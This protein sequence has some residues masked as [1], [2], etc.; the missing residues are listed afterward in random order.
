MQT[1]EAM[2]TIVMILTLR[3]QT[4][5]SSELQQLAYMCGTRAKFLPC[6]PF[7]QPIKEDKVTRSAKGS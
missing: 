2:M 6:L 4:I 1:I 3:I 5:R 7:L